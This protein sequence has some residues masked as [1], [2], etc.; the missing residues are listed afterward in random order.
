[1]NNTKE[2][3]LAAA[4]HLFAQNGY[5]AV[6]VSN[7]AE[8]LGIT[9]GALYKHYKNKR[10]IFDSIVS[11]ME[12]LDAERA[13]EYELPEGTLAEMEESYENASVKQ[14]IAFSLAQ[15]RYWTEEE[16]PASFRKMLTLEQ[17]RSKEMGE[18]YQQYLVSGPLSYVTDIFRARKVKDAREKAIK[19]YAPMF[20][21]YSIYDGDEDKGLS[22][23]VL[24]EHLECLCE[25]WMENKQ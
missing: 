13:A 19:L 23:A 7:I 22:S 24:Q 8:A 17:Y 5:E 2:N 14:L 20:L 1:M 3:I 6:S 16:F 21:F 10:D 12:R 9:K 11:R 4:L 15:F 18:L 25:E